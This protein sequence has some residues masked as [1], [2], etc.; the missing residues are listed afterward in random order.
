MHNLGSCFDALTS[1]RFSGSRKPPA[2]AGGEQEVRVPEKSKDIGCWEIHLGL[3]S[4][5]KSDKKERE[6]WAGGR[7]S[8]K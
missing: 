4:G 7:L 2:D 3:R 1:P 5:C 6:T 8:S